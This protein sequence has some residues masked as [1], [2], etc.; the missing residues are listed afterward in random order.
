MRDEP[1]SWV[2]GPVGPVPPPAVK[3]DFNRPLGVSAALVNAPRAQAAAAA[4][5]TPVDPVDKV[6]RVRKEKTTPLM[7]V[8]MRP[9]VLTVSWF[10]AQMT[11][12]FL[13]VAYQPPN[14]TRGIDGLLLC[15]QD[16][17]SPGTWTPPVADLVGTSGKIYVPEFECTYRGVDLVCSHLNIEILDNNVRYLIFRAVEKHHVE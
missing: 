6:T 9:A 12:P 13:H 10:G 17:S 1:E 4:P 3:R 16:T 2:E 7:E 14:P 15:V 5:T 11:I 8:A